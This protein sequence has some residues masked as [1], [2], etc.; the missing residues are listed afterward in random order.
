MSL[1]ATLKELKSPSARALPIEVRIMGD[2]DAPVWTPFT[3][4]IKPSTTG[5]QFTAFEKLC[6]GAR[7]KHNNYVMLSAVGAKPIAAC[8]V[9]FKPGNQL[10]ISGYK[11]RNEQE[12]YYSPPLAF[13]IDCADAVFENADLGEIP[14]WKPQDN[15]ASLVARKTP[16]CVDVV[17]KVVSIGEY[18]NTKKRRDVTLVDA[19]N[20]TLDVMLFDPLAQNIDSVADT[21]VCFT[22]MQVKINSGA[23]SAVW[24]DKE[25]QYGILSKIAIDAPQNMEATTA[26]VVPLSSSRRY[27]EETV[28]CYTCGEVDYVI[29]NGAQD[30]SKMQDGLVVEVDNV[31]VTH[32]NDPMESVTVQRGSSPGSSLRVAVCVGDRTGSFAA[33]V[34]ERAALKIYAGDKEALNIDEVRNLVQRGWSPTFITSYDFRVKID[35]NAASDGEDA[36]KKGRATIV[37][38]RAAKDQDFHRASYLFSDGAVLPT[39][40]SSFNFDEVFQ[41]ATITHQNRLWPLANSVFLEMILTGASK[42]DI[43]NA[44]AFLRITNYCKDVQLESGEPAKK[45]ARRSSSEPTALEASAICG[46]SKLLDHEIAETFL[47][48]VIGSDVH[49]NITTKTFGM[50]IVKA[51]RITQGDAGILKSRF[52]KSSAHEVDVCKEHRVQEATKKPATVYTVLADVRPSSGSWQL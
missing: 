39:F 11:V 22:N 20:H 2:A 46:A 1:I 28:D 51:Q 24:S 16:R 6:V 25:T 37:A 5:R 47:Y 34:W 44:G 14:A 30:I 52:L 43:D 35:F 13:S 33:I 31:F 36:A 50:T 29:N 7:D 40:V 4:K 45:L 49:Y 18:N 42:A 48:H 3:Q 38:V 12:R 17:G 21:V 19:S 23:V 15:I 27:E 8:K 41:Q 9:H 26:V 10:R 32:V